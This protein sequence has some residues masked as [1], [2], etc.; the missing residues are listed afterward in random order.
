MLVF[1]QSMF[2]NG[3]V[4]ISLSTIEKRFQM[5]S[6]ESGFIS[7]A[8]DIASVLC[9]IPVGYFGG[10]GSKPRWLG[11]GAMFMATGAFIFALPHF[12]TGEYS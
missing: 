9:C 8:Y 4:N 3:M 10:I 12:L 7:S 6:Q 11:F 1:C 2:V 5:D